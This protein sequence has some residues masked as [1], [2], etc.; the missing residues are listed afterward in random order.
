MYGKVGYG[1]LIAV[2][3][4]EIGAMDLETVS[5]LQDN[6]RPITGDFDRF[7][8]AIWS[9]AV[10]RKWHL[11]FMQDLKEGKKR[12]NLDNAWKTKKHAREWAKYSREYLKAL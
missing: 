6:H 1:R 11:I 3:K 5:N 4:R 9:L 10:A 7:R 8:H 2:W 12:G